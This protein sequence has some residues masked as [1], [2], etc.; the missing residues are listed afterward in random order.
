MNQTRQYE[1][2]TDRLKELVIAYVNENTEENL[3]KIANEIQKENFLET[4]KLIDLAI[5]EIK[6]ELEKMSDK[7][8]SKDYLDAKLEALEYKID[9]KLE[10]LEHKFDKKIN[11]LVM[12]N[13]SIKKDIKYY[14]FAIIALMIILQPKV[15]DFISN[16][17]S[18]SK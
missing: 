3:L 11:E 17:F 2:V 4:K 1:Y 15:I 13:K 16:V 8:V 7:F 18:V 5:V 9:K 12:E 6:K 10:S 14:A